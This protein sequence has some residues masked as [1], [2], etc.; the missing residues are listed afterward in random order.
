MAENRIIVQKISDKNGNTVTV[1]CGDLENPFEVIIENT[2]GSGHKFVR[3]DCIWYLIHAINVE[4]AHTTVFVNLNTGE[5]RKTISLNYWRGSLTMSPNGK[6]AIIKGGII[7]SSAVQ[8]LVY[9]LTD[10]DNVNI[11]YREEIWTF[12]EYNVRFDK[13]S[14]VVFEYTFEFWSLDD[15]VSLVGQETA[16]DDEFCKYLWNENNSGIE[17]KKYYSGSSD[18]LMKAGGEKIWITV[19][20]THARNPTLITPDAPE[21]WK[22][23]ESKKVYESEVFLDEMEIIKTEKH[24]GTPKKRNNFQVTTANFEQFLGK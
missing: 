9:D 6:L 10:W 21:K 1:K 22:I 11:I 5:T 17:M 4:N 15:K 2:Y 24:L 14:N 20:V 18:D 7:A 8:I 19:T 3:D 23:A 13:D 12:I 16:I